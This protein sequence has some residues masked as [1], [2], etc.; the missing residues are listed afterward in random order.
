M[1]D[2]LNLA[3]HL[4]QLPSDDGV[5]NQLLP[6]GRSLVCKCPGFF[7]EASAEP[8]RLHN[9]TPALM[10]EVLHD[11]AKALVLL[12]DQVGQGNLHLVELHV[13]RPTRPDALAIHSLGGDPRHSLLQEKHGNAP[14]ALATR[15]HGAGE[16]VGE[17]PVGDPLLV[18]VDNVEVT[19]PSCRGLD[20][21]NVAASVWLRDVQGDDLSPHEAI[22][23]Y[24]FLHLICA[25]V[26]DRRKANL[27]AL[28]Q[29]PQNTT[30]GTPG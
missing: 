25:K 21:R 3:R 11:D 30:A 27:Q 16:V 1:M 26:Q 28:N 18:A 8:A 4:R 7:D 17:D 15:A 5:L 13:G 19:F 23:C 2:A 6:K 22:R 9:E 14:H 10:I 12:A 20:S 24:T 29:A